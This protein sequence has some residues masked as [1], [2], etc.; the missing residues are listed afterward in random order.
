MTL[1]D[2]VQQLSSESHAK[3]FERYFNRIDLENRIKIYAAKGITSCTISVDNKKDDYLKTRLFNS[4]TID[5]LRDRLGDGFS[6]ELKT[7][8][9]KSHVSTFFNIT[10]TYIEISW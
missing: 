6:V 4:K 5:M 8:T 2:E 7:E 1:F 10:K 3:W 9:I